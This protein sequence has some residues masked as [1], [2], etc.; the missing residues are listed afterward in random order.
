MNNVFSRSWKAS[1]SPRKQRKYRYNAPSHLRRVML[2]AHL[3]K[4][5]RQKYGRRS[6][7]VRTGDTVKVV[8]GSFK[9]KQGLIDRVSYSRML[10]YV[11][12]CERVTVKGQKVRV[13][14]DASNVIVTVL[15]LNDKRRVAALERKQKIEQTRT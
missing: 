11:A 5:L 15:K 13:G 12:G 4:P 1:T 9:G 10:V 14:I 3:D 7:P 6:I 2:S 8:R